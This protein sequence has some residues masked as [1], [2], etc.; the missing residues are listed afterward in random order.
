M[1]WLGLDKLLLGSSLDEAQA[2]SNALDAQIQAANQKLEA[3][4][5]IP[6]G[7]TDKAAIDISAGNDSTGAS[8][9]VAS[10]NSEFKAG[11]AE[12]LNNVLTAPGKAVGAIGGGASTLL[13]GILKNIPWWVYLAGAGAL[14]V[15]MGGLT[16]LKGRFARK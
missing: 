13:W 7:Y 5:Y 4:G 8:D 9:V 1:S 16:L 11:A 3:A 6:T 10:V 2:Q 14:F 15:W 12:G